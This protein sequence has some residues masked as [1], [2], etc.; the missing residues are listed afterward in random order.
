MVEFLS[1]TIEIKLTGE[2]EGLLVGFIVGVTLGK[3][4]GFEEGD[5]LYKISKIEWRVRFNSHHDFLTGIKLTGKEGLLVGFNEEYPQSS[6]DCW[7]RE[8]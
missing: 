4:V 5:R 7:T 6:L 8:S 3:S 1:E 2:L